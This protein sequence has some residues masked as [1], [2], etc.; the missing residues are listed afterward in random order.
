[1]AEAR[2]EANPQREETCRERAQHNEGGRKAEVMRDHP[3]QCGTERGTCRLDR[4]DRSL[5]CVHTAGAV[6]QTHHERRHYDALQPGESRALA[7]WAKRRTARR[8]ARGQHLA[9]HAAACSDRA[10]GLS[11]PRRLCASVGARREES[12][13]FGSTIE[14]E[15]IAYLVDEGSGP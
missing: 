8:A 14:V 1:M 15:E 7:L 2:A 5:A 12:V 10:R 3:A 9:A 13:R 6:E 11:H 4:H